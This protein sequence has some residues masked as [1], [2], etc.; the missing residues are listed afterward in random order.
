MQSTVKVRKYAT[1][2]LNTLNPQ[3]NNEIISVGRNMKSPFLLLFSSKIQI[4]LSFLYFL[5][6][7]SGFKLSRLTSH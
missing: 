1:Q 3:A 5:Q 7:K 2:I 4:N 6:G